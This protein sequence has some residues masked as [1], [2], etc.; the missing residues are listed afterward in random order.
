M[1]NR[2]LGYASL[3]LNLRDSSRLGSVTLGVDRGDLNSND[4]RSPFQ[5]K[6][7]CRVLCT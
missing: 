5:G 6:L 2:Q 3:S 7:G 4:P 1:H